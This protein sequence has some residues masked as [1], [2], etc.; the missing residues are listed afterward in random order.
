[1]AFHVETD[2]PFT[3]RVGWSDEPPDDAADVFPSGTVFLRAVLSLWGVEVASAWLAVNEY[4]IPMWPTP[5]FDNAAVRMVVEDV[6]RKFAEALA[7]AVKEGAAG[8][9]HQ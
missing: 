5:G 3:I 9:V 8:A 6:K 7:G 4:V 2:G 1:M